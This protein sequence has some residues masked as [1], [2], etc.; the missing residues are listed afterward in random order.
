MRPRRPLALLVLASVT[1]ACGRRAHLDGPTAVEQV[2]RHGERA[3]E[4][5]L[6]V[7]ATLDRT[8]PVALVLALHGHGGTGHGMEQLTL[9]RLDRLADRDGAVIAYPDGIDHRWND[10]L[11][12]SSVDDVGFLVA[13]VDALAA[14]L[15][16]DRARVFVT[17]MSN[18][19]F[20]S[21]RLACARPDVFAAFAPVA[22]GLRGPPCEPTR[23]VPMLFVNGTADPLVTYDGTTVHFGDRVLSEK[24]T[25]SDA[26]ARFAERDGCTAPAEYENLPDRDP[27]D[28]ST[29]RVERRAGCRDTAEVL[30]YRVEGG[31]HTWPGGFQ[32][33]GE[34]WIGRTN[35]DLDATDVIWS[36]FQRHPIAR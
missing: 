24:R 11:D 13:L 19:G 25:T 34:R 3:R 26:V 22:A 8:R 31:G 18:G 35:R 9:G 10:M 7:P 23:A 4:Y 21:V 30:L 29:V 27:N 28:G 32:Y 15:P 12:A 2:L 36:F 33:L 16:I 1:A 20:M 14:R 6:Y 17:G 5:R